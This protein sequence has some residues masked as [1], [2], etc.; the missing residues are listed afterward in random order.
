MKSNRFRKGL[1]AGIIILLISVSVL[2]SVSS[3]S[4]ISVSKKIVL[5][6]TESDGNSFFGY[7][8]GRI[9]NVSEDEY[10]P[11][12]EAVNLYI[13]SLIPFGFYHL[14]SGEEVYIAAI[15]PDNFFLIGFLT[16]NFI[17]GLCMHVNW[18]Y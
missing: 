15:A 3:A 12:F 10:G 17:I 2:S 4:D 13:V 14:N 6:N 9:K 8:C 11:E 7:L 5:K 1:V 18:Y 16:N